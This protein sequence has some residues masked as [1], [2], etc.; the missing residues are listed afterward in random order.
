MVDSA[1]PGSPEPAF[2]AIC[3]HAPSHMAIRDPRYCIHL[4]KLVR[5]PTG[6]GNPRAV[7]GQFRHSSVA[8]TLRYTKT[9]SQD[10]SMVIR[11]RADHPWRPESSC[12]TDCYMTSLGPTLSNRAP[13]CPTSGSSLTQWPEPSQRQHGFPALVVRPQIERPVVWRTSDAPSVPPFRKCEHQYEVVAGLLSKAPEG[14]SPV[15]SHGAHRRFWRRFLGRSRRVARHSDLIRGS[16]CE[17]ESFEVLQAHFRF[18]DAAPARTVLVIPMR[19]QHRGRRERPSASPHL[20]VLLRT[21]G[22]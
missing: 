8:V 13:T 6:D 16:E 2:S 4:P 22:Y 10:E 17:N 9:N 14:L 19:R 1:V 18:P 21:I 11:G 7:Q 5:A 12:G 3:D 15:G 20:S